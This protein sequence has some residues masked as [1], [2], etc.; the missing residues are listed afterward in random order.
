MRR[1][2][3]FQFRQLVTC[4]PSETAFEASLKMEDNRVGCVLV[5]R[6][7][8]IEGIATRYDFIHH[9]IVRGLDPHKTKIS[10]IMHT[11]PVKI[12]SSL[13]MVDA[14][15]TDGE[16]EGGAPSGRQNPPTRSSE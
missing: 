15:K 10:E 6:E 7:G 14:L 4:S 13:T 2:D 1:L 9:L 11:S 5:T 16:K 8:K 3:E 12:E